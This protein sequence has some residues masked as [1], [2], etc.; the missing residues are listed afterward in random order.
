M[1][2]DPG[3]T[4]RPDVTDLR[5]ALTLGWAS[6]QRISGLHIGVE[7]AGGARVPRQV[8]LVGRSAARTVQLDASGSASFEPLDTD[9]LQIV[10][11]GDDDDP[12]ARAVVGIGSLSL[13]GSPEL[14]PGPDPA[15][16]VPCV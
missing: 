9:Q 2:G 15:F 16:T 8:Q 12:A 5:P 10:L 14:L 7:P 11:P 13:S 4:W 6:P 3:T 1:D